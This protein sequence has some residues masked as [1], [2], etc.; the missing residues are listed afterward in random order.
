[1]ASNQN[2]RTLVVLEYAFVGEML[3]V[4]RFKYQKPRTPYNFG[5]NSAIDYD[6]QLDIN[7]KKHINQQPQTM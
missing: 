6:I 4:F 1:M 3:H 7:I 5:N 2:S